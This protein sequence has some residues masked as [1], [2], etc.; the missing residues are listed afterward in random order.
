MKFFNFGR[1]GR[2]Q[3]LVAKI[4]RGLGGLLDGE[5][6]S[7]FSAKEETGMSLGENINRLRTGKNMSQGD[8][9]EA[10]EVSRQS[11]SKW[12]TDGAVPELDKLVRLSELF[13]VSLDELVM[14]KKPPE[15]ARPEQTAPVKVIVERRGMEGRK[16]A[17][18]LLLGMA[19]L[20]LLVCTAGRVFW[21]GVLLGTPFFVCGLIC[22]LVERYPGLW[23]A[24]ALY[25]MVDGFLRYGTGLNWSAVRFTFL[26][27]ESWNYTRLA[28]AWCQLLC[29]L[30]LLA[31]T[32]VR[33]GKE[34]MEWTRRS[35]GHFIGGAALFALLCLP[36]GT[37]IFQVGGLSVSGLV[38]FLG[39][40]QDGLR[41]GLLAGL[42]TMLV[43]GRK[44]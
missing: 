10:L 35:R 7:F 2:V 25:L 43:R 11:I 29:A 41:L 21:L 12:E 16:A 26:W 40:L 4:S 8:L 33:L 44:R 32:V 19:F 17:A 39:W 3:P 38:T 34:P 15:E 24:W 20:A 30:A 31:G 1:K 13:G 6:V 23:C 18:I 14:G 9:A 42:G 37:W 27:E 36:F 5:M 22:L 28:I